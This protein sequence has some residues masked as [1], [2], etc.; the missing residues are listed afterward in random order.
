[1]LF[2]F[3]VDASSSIGSG[4]V[5]R[6]LNL[7]H[8]LS[9]RGGRIIFVMRPLGGNLIE[10][11]KENGFDVLEICSQFNDKIISEEIDATEF[12]EVISN[13][14]DVKHEEKHTK[15]WVVV[16]NY[17]LSSCWE[18][19]VKRIFSRIVA[20]DDVADRTHN[21]D[22]LIDQN[23]VESENSRYDNLIPFYSE[24]L[25][26]PKYAMIDSE[27]KFERCKLTRNSKIINNIIIYFGLSDKKMTLMAVESLCVLPNEFSALIVID[28]HNVQIE[29]I[30]RIVSADKRFRVSGQLPR[31]THIMA[32]SDLF[33]GACGT[34]S[35]E[36]LCL[37]LR[38]VVVTLADNQEALARTLDKNGFIYWLGRSETITK[39]TMVRGLKKALNTP[40]DPSIASRMMKMVDGLGAERVADMLM[41][42]GSEG[43]KLRMVQKSDSDT[44]LKWA[45]DPDTRRN[46]F[47]NAQI[48]KN[49]H[50]VWFRRQ[51]DSPRIVFYLA[52]TPHGEPVGHVRFEYQPDH[53]W[54]ISYLVAP[55]FRRR[56]VARIMLQ[57]C[58]AK[59][60]DDLGNKFLS[61]YVKPTNIASLRVFKLLGF[62][63]SSQQDNPEAIR[64]EL[65]RRF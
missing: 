37:G 12:V 56:G 26:G 52:L 51:I 22:L 59:I 15:T 19:Q 16:D 55:F 10:R 47:N 61:A 64:F 34:T 60:F 41:F 33:V 9:F 54:Q 31:L 58:I 43:M 7:A 65:F 3:R 6:C 21:V 29:S 25:I 36:R 20:I 44:I 63:K 8:C 11:V 32:E 18:S 49:E 2:I 40:L 62:T 17:K 39:T 50:S 28:D 5:M 27:Y 13:Y 48:S 4:H 1:M 46:A 42:D 57:Q 23:L 53:S 45:N 30:N 38:A 24:T 14:E 35:W